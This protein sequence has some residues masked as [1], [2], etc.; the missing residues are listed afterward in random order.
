MSGVANSQST[1]TFELDGNAT[2]WVGRNP[3]SI[4]GQTNPTLALTPGERYEI[5]C[6]NVDGQAHNVEL[7][8]GD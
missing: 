2:G 1:T 5:T 4:A 7:L 3:E 6:T 8:D